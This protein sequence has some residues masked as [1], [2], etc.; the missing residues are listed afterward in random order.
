[1]SEG[2]MSNF[3]LRSD[4]IDLIRPL[5]KAANTPVAPFKFVHQPCGAIIIVTSRAV[6]FKQQ[7]DAVSFVQSFVVSF[8][9]KAVPKYIT[10]KQCENIRFYSFITSKSD[11]IRIQTNKNN[12]RLFV[13]FI[14]RPGTSSFYSNTPLSQN[15]RRPPGIHGNDTTSFSRVIVTFQIVCPTDVAVLFNNQAIN[16]FGL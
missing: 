6:T 10:S 11:I 4:N 7:H 9:S 16:L 14:A 12:N 15:A 5:A 2:M 13:N 3:K 8:S 1:M